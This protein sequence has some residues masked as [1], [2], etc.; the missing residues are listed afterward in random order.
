MSILDRPTPL[1]KHTTYETVI[2]RFGE[3]I[4]DS[5]RTIRNRILFDRLKQQLENEM[6]LKPDKQDRRYVYNVDTAGGAMTIRMS[7]VTANLHTSPLLI[8]FR[9]AKVSAAA[10]EAIKAY[11][12]KPN[13]G[14]AD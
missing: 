7:G 9:G 12:A 2:S 11:L 8:G 13:P 6:Y 1:I 3:P 5:Q 10:E 4:S 14:T